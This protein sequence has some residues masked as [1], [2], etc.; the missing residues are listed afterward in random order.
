MK[1]PSLLIFVLASFIPEPWDREEFGGP[2]GALTHNLHD[3]RELAV[4]ES[5]NLDN[6]LNNRLVLLTGEPPA[7]VAKYDATPAGL[8]SLNLDLAG[9]LASN[10]CQ[11][12][13]FQSGSVSQDALPLSNPRVATN[14][15]F[16][17]VASLHPGDVIISCP[18]DRRPVHEKQIRP[19][20]G[21]RLLKYQLR[22]L[23]LAVVA[24][25]ELSS[26]IASNRVVFGNFGFFGGEPNYCQ[27][28]RPAIER[29]KKYVEE[30]ISKTGRQWRL[31]KANRVVQNERG[32]NHDSRLLNAF[33]A[34][35]DQV[36]PGDLII[37][38]H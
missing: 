6:I 20:V 22:D 5:E 18:P 28:N 1:L 25:S 14:S 15:A 32:S 31:V 19:G 12:R 27:C 34:E 35:I 13:L 33:L 7:L 38:C 36:E 16:A 10:D 23:R 24:E 9:R 29:I 17:Q 8:A 4:G 37:R 11:I 3:L 2:D 30:S 21:H 26:Y